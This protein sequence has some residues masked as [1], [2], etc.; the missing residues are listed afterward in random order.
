MYIYR[1]IIP[2]FVILITSVTPIISKTV[3]DESIASSILKISANSSNNFRIF[4]SAI[5]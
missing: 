4:S 2:L 3:T 5:G 1:Y